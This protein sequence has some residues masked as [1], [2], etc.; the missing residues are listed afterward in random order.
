MLKRLSRSRKHSHSEHDHFCQLTDDER[1]KEYHRIAREGWDKAWQ[2]YSNKDG[3]K[4][5]SGKDDHS[6][7]VLSKHLDSGKV[8]KLEGFV[9]APWEA[10]FEQLVHGDNDSPEWNPTVLHC[11]TL[12]KINHNT[13]IAYNISCG[14]AGGLVTS[15]DY[16]NLRHWK[17]KD[18]VCLSLGQSV[19]HPEKPPTKK[20]VRA[21]NNP[22]AW[23]FKKIDE[24]MSHFTMILKSDLKGW[25]PQSVVDQAMSGV[26]MNY[27]HVLRTR[28]QHV[29]Q[30]NHGSP[31]AAS[32]LSCK[33]SD[34]SLGNGAAENEHAQQ[35]EIAVASS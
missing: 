26:L 33:L 32:E 35:P 7:V 4:L 20:Y 12:Q 17:N 27:I 8:F 25:L 11:S 29:L 22:A 30:E 34:M 1:V 3:W 2:I 10:V 16:V 31:R 6:G 15:R 14:G 13:D 28:L 18:D 23:A 24:K 21:E 9:H 5:M 19:C